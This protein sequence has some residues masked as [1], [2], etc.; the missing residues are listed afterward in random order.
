MA[1]LIDRRAAETEQA[2]DKL[3]RKF[4]RSAVVKGLSLDSDD[5]DDDGQIA[6]GKASLSEFRARS[7]RR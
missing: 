5:E 6:S 1:D 2:I 4:G 3:R 7:G